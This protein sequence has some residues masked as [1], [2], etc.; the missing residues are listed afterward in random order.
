MKIFVSVHC[1]A[2]IGRSGTLILVDSCLQMAEAGT[3]LT[4]KI[5]FDTLLEMRTQRWG[6][7]QTEQQLKFSVD[8]IIHGLKNTDLVNGHSSC[9]KQSNHT[10]GKRLK[11]D[12]ES[13]DNT[14]NENDE[15]QSKSK[16]R[17]NSES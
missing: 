15:G 13:D 10:N 3:E 14:D 4:L 8:A 16:K 5:I 2:G 6:L 12:R 11:E 7:I 17:K 9:G 1:S